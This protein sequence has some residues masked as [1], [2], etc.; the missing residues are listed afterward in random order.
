[1]EAA[2]DLPGLAYARLHET[3]F[4]SGLGDAQR[5]AQAIGLVEPVV[6]RLPSPQRAR[7]E[8]TLHGRRAQLALLRGDAEAAL[9]EVE[10]A[11]APGTPWDD[12]GA[13]G[14][15]GA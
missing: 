11:E 15:T 9:R 8:T 10:A 13:E 12:P 6:A 4:L 2:G 3:A 7:A 14:C 5:L 1:M